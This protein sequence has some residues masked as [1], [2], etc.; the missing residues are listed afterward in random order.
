MMSWASAAFSRARDIYRTD[1]AFTLLKTS[2]DYI[3]RHIFVYNSYYLYVMPLGEL[4]EAEFLPQIGDLTCKI[5]SSNQEADE[6]AASFSFD[7]RRRFVDAKKKLDNGAIAFCIF[8]GKEFASIGWVSLTQESQN[9]LDALPLKVEYSAGEAY[10][11]AA[12]TI[13][14]YRNN[15]LLKYGSLKRRQFL[16]EKGIRVMRA[17]VAE[18]TIASHRVSA[19]LGGKIYAKAHHIKIL[20]WNYWKEKPQ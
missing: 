15:R 19:R 3:R 8:V 7:I 20:W 5:I 10:V 14:K 11:G 18:S 6:L 13:P 16:T 1:G 4:N 12:E 9:T 2:F 17:A